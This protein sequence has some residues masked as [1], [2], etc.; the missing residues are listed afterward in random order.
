[1][2]TKTTTLPNFD[3]AIRELACKNRR[4]SKPSGNRASEIGA[5]N[6]CLRKLVYARTHWDQRRQPDDTLMGIFQTGNEVE[7]IVVR[8]LVNIGRH[9]G[10]RL[11]ETQK[12]L[13]YPEY[14]I[15]GHCDG[16]IEVDN[17]IVAGIEIKS[18]GQRFVAL[19]DVESLLSWDISAKW[20][21]QAQIYMMLSGVKL[22][23]LLLVQKNNLYNTR[24]I[25]I[26][27][28]EEFADKILDRAK[29]INEHIEAGTLPDKIN[30]PRKCDTCQF[31]HICMPDLD[32]TGKSV[33]I[34]DEDIAAALDRMDELSSAKSEYDKCEKMVNQVKQFLPKAGPETVEDFFTV[35]V[36]DKR[37]CFV[38]R[39]R[40]T[41][42]SKGGTSFFWQ[43]H[44]NMEDTD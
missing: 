44:K 24:T 14:E 32:T 34:L 13:E 26:E 2:E 4:V 43:R 22:W 28:D 20:Y 30:D 19:K 15:V 29:K 35:R 33:A 1:M 31:A 40:T 27:L 10:F 23:A 38:G 21:G 41:A 37:L 9:D 7:E 6:E 39:K 11:I 3:G 5:P 36:I 17:E 16:L 8:N 25:W 42:P 18:V 12:T